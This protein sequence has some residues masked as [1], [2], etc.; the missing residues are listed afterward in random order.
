MDKQAA[1]IQK[2][3]TLFKS[4]KDVVMAFVFGSR[5]NGAGRSQS[6]WD[7]A[8]YLSS[9]EKRIEW[10]SDR[11]Y[12]QEQEIWRD[13]TE[14]LA[15]DAVDLL[16]LNKAPASMAETALRGM[17]LVVKD[18][19]VWLKFMSVI[20]SAAEEY[21]RFVDE[22]YAISQRSASLTPRDKEDLK[23]TINFVEEQIRLYSIYQ[24]FTLDDFEQ[25]PR[26][27]NEIERWLE[28]IVNA[29][30]D[31]SKVVLGSKKRRVPPTYREAVSRTVRE[32]KLSKEFVD[33][34][35]RWVKLRNELAHEYLDIKWKRIADFAGTSE[36]V[37]KAFLKATKKF[38]KET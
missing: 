36:Q 5:A 25:D 2:L 15:T 17:P 33:Y 1:K 23:R 21:R 13:C 27:R 35:E 37:I 16:I 38:L 20:T 26:K 10:E 18:S 4:R 14:I 19:G 32:F 6:D 31:I 7:I 28:N 3:K 9:P 30:I 11:D 29:V 8:V 24:S 22:F 34:F 12:R